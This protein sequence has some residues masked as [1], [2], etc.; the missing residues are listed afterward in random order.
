MLMFMQ[1]AFRFLW[2]LYFFFECLL[3]QMDFVQLL[4]L[5]FYALTAI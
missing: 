1:Y 3:E 5:G 2:F 4:L